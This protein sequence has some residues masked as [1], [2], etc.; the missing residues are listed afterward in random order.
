MNIIK[1]IKQKL[2]AKEASIESAPEDVPPAPAPPDSF[3]R[4]FDKVSEEKRRARELDDLGRRDA[5][6]EDEALKR[7]LAEFRLR[8]PD[9]GSTDIDQAYKERFKC[10]KCDRVFS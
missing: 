9:C 3:S 10:R 2:F 6:R 7:R 4:W 1:Q 5:L 8:C